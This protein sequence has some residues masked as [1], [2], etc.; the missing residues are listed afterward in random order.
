M[1]LAVF[2]TALNVLVSG[3]VIRAVMTAAFQVLMNGFVVRTVMIAALE[4]LMNRFVIRAVMVTVLEIIVY[5]L[6]VRAVMIA[7]LKVAVD[8]MM[9]GAV[10][11]AAFLT[12]MMRMMVRAVKSGIRSAVIVIVVPAAMMPVSHYRCRKTA[13]QNNSC[14]YSG[15]GFFAVLKKIRFQFLPISNLLLIIRR[16]NRNPCKNFAK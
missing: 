1:I 16:S 13:C 15:Q 10:I 6:V 9:I 4:V 14:H 2:L 3:F 7:V 5:C 12:V 8:F 11:L